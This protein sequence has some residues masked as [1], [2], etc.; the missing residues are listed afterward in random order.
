M[1]RKQYI[2]KLWYL[3][4]TI[5]DHPG[6]PFPDD[7]KIELAL[8]HVKKHAKK[9]KKVFGSYEEAWDCTVKMVRELYT[10]GE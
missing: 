10:K 1:T 4:I 2:H 8:K 9:A 6:N 7:Y 5:Y 3:L